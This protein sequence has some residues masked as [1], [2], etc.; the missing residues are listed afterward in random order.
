MI[1]YVEHLFIYLLAICI[2]SLLRLIEIFFLFLNRFSYCSIFKSFLFVLNP[3]SDM[4]FANTFPQTVVCLFILLKISYTRGKNNFNKVKLI[5]LFFHIYV[6]LSQ[7]HL[8]RLFF[9]H[10][11]AFAFSLKMSWIYAHESIWGLFLFHHLMNL[12][13][14]NTTLSWFL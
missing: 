1:N 11:I 3:S 4:H 6:K 13:S 8:I 9:F 5:N 14:T 12:S 2:S 7:H 10:Q